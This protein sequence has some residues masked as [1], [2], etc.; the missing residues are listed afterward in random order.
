MSN[1]AIHDLETV[2]SL[3]RDAMSH[4]DGGYRYSGIGWAVPYQRPGSGSL[5]QFI[6]V[7]ELNQYFVNTDHFELN[8]VS[9]IDIDAAADNGANL[10][11]NLLLGQAG[12]G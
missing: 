4:I 2:E 1:L 5:P 7:G 8:Q 10:N 11:I 9:V 12:L 3:S 6:Y